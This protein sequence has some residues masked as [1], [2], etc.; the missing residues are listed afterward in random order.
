MAQ[1]GMVEKMSKV[2]IF[3]YI[4]L[5]SSLKYKSDIVFSVFLSLDQNLMKLEKW[6]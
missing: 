6:S 2:F 1:T 5:V 3:T 4:S